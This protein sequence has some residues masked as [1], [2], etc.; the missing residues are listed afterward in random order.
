MKLFF[1]L[2]IKQFI[3]PARM[4][5]CALRASKLKRALANGLRPLIFGELPTKGVQSKPKKR[6]KIVV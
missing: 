6:K 1:L 4:P 3:F 2:C 5:A